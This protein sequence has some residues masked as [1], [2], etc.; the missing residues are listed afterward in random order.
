MKFCNAF[1]LLLLIFY[2]GVNYAQQ[3]SSKEALYKKNIKR[4]LGLTPNLNYGLY[5]DF[6]KTE[7]SRKLDFAA[8]NQSTIWLATEASINNPEEYLDNISFDRTDLLAPAL[9]KFNEEESLKTLRTILGMA[10]ITAVGYLA[11]R[12]IKKFGLLK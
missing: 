4:R 6:N 8:K 5:S 9:L 11:Y 7:T 1:I 10:Q 2:G 3:D 12:H